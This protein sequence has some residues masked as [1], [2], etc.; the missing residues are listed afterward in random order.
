MGIWDSYACARA[1]RY[2]YTM[3]RPH[4]LPL[5]VY[6]Y[7]CVQ[8]DTHGKWRGDSLR[9]YSNLGGTTDGVTIAEIGVQVSCSRH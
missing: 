3:E 7:R 9:R 1:C 4:P 5:D 8:I 6:Q 2:I